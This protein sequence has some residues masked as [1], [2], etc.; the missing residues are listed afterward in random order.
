MS[1]VPQELVGTTLDG[2][3]IEAGLGSGS[4]ADIYLARHP[5]LE[6]KVAVKV[7]SRTSRMGAESGERLLREGEL[8]ASFDH[9][10]IPHVYGHGE[11]G[12]VFYLAMA[13]AES[14][15]LMHCLERDGPLSLV[16]MLSVVD[17]LASVVDTLHAADIVHTDAKLSNILLG[18]SERIYLSDFGRARPIRKHLALPRAR[19]CDIAAVAS[20]AYRCLMGVPKTELEA[21]IAN[22]EGLRSIASA[23]GDVPASVD[24]VLA[25]VR[26]HAYLT[27]DELA[28]SLHHAA[29][30]PPTFAQP[31]RIGLNR[32]RRLLGTGRA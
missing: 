7:P 23:R 30:T 12:G 32:M 22:R 3:S 5:S 1:D 6:L 2:Y 31:R 19:A 20:V 27:A 29:E 28:Q 16:Q 14:R 4:N 15:D 18:S 26:S 9:P 25:R 10:G 13:Y 11:S 17:Q 21:V 8:M 24:G